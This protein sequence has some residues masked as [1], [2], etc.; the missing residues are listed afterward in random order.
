[1][2]KLEEVILRDTRANQPAAGDV[3][4]G[5]IYYV[6][7]ENVTERSSGSAWEDISD[8]SS[9][10]APDDVD[11]LVGTATGDLSAEIVVGTSPGGELG[12]TW[13]SPTVDAT[14][15]GSTHAATQAAA[16][17]TAAAALSGH[18]GDTSDAHDA[19]AISLADAGGNTSETDVEGAIDELYGLVGGG[20]ATIRACRVTR[21]AALNATTSATLITW[22]NEVRDDGG[23]W[24]AGAPTKFVIPATGWYAVGHNIQHANN[25]S[26]WLFSELKRNGS[27]YM[28]QE[29]N[30]AATSPKQLNFT[31]VDYFTAADELEVAISAQATVA[32]TVGTKFNFWIHQVG[33]V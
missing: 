26:D 12:G 18:T 29:A 1:M 10:G 27:A 21:N 8:A 11:Y 4:A 32:L 15:S 3:A 23:F 30:Q 28:D 7:D 14:H 31:T 25:A 5:T 20:S 9:G 6:T 33:G 13:A 19:S 24:S 17:A 2:A 16:E 22:D